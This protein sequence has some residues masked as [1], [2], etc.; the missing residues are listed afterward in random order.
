MKYVDKSKG[1]GFI[2]CDETREEFDRDIFVD[3][4]K[5]PPG[6]ENSGDPISFM[7]IV[8]RRGFPEASSCKSG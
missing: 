5:L 8:G 7:V 6:I 3:N 4:T 1:F 2:V